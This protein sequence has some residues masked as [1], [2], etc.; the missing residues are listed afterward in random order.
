MLTFHCSLGPMKHK[1]SCLLSQRPIVP[2]KVSPVDC[3]SAE[4]AISVQSRW[5]RKPGALGAM[6]NSMALCPRLNNRTNVYTC[7]CALH[8]LEEGPPTGLGD[9][10]NNGQRDGA[11]P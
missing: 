11:L 2:L 8:D 5:K 7:P 4:K 9:S 10:Q 6:S 3:V 1:G